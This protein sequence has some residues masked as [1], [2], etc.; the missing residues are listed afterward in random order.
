MGVVVGTVAYMSPEQARG[1]AVDHRSDVFSLGILLYEMVTGQ[2]PFSGNSPLDTM[3]AIA[4]EESR[5]LSSVR[6]NLPPSMQR[7]VNRCLRKRA[8]DR[9]AEMSHLVN[10][11]K[12]VQREIET[13]I[14]QTVPIGERIRD[15][16]ASLKELTPSEWAWPIAGVLGLGAL[17]VLLILRG[18][19]LMGVLIFFGIVGLIV[20]RRIRNRRF[21]MMKRFTAKVRK[22]PEVRIIAL[23]G[24]RAVVLVDKALAKTYV[25]VNALMDKVNSKMFYGEPF[26]VVVRE[27]QDPREER[28]L[29][30]GPGVLYVR[31]D[32]LE[33]TA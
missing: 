32:V 13:G 31:K 4:F 23:Q 22:M 18:E 11:L 29:L 2:L 33:P 5:P 7:V 25:R 12:G 30:E 8:D 3:H 21:R 27:N 9:Y 19:D 15:G 10:D 20:W 26:S 24:S 6:G 14:S 17:L 28:A 16:L 1:Q